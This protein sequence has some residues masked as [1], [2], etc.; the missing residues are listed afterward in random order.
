MELQ[1]LVTQEREKRKLFDMEERRKEDM[2][3]NATVVWLRHDDRD[4]LFFKQKLDF[5]QI[6]ANLGQIAIE[7]HRDCF[8][9]TGLQ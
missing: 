3:I 5:S 4:A 8:V 2:C 7:C 9:N 1:G 6:V